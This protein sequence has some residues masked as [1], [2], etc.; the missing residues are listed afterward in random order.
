MLCHPAGPGPGSGPGLF[1]SEVGRPGVPGS[2]E[3]DGPSLAGTAWPGRAGRGGLPEP[4]P[5]FPAGAGPGRA[6]RA[7]CQVL[8]SRGLPGSALY[9]SLNTLG[10]LRHATMT[11]VPRDQKGSSE[12]PSL[13]LSSSWTDTGEPSWLGRTHA[14]C[15]SA[16][17]GSQRGSG[18]AGHAGRGTGLY[19]QAG[20]P[21]PRVET[22]TAT[23]WLLLRDKRS[24]SRL[25]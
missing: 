19:R 14:S 13:Y 12:L 20:F 23:S 16:A 4:T 2:P 17:A 22:V 9:P 15:G 21:F 18:S 8:P 6:G 25:L 7:V 11:P 1:S 5:R 10:A 24:L 3:E